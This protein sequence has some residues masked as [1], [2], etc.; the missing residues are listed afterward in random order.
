LDIRICLEFSAWSLG[1]NLQ[2]ASASCFASRFCSCLIHQAQLPNKLGNY[3]FK[4]GL[5]RLRLATA[6][7]PR[8]DKR[9]ASFPAFFYCHCELKAWQSQE[10][11]TQKSKGK[12]TEQSLKM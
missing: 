5:L 2:G 7:A 4:R 12:M 10:S 11:K 3:I 8:N 1:L 6:A 9:D